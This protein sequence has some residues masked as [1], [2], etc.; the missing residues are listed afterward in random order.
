MLR[1]RARPE[2]GVNKGLPN[3]QRVQM[4][5]KTG[6]PIQLFVGLKPIASSLKR[7]AK[8]TDDVFSKLNES[9]RYANTDTGFYATRR[10]LEHY[11][12]DA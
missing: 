5:R 2:P 1:F 3:Y 8:N 7:N 12:P 6:L 4:K 11:A 9:Y 10:W